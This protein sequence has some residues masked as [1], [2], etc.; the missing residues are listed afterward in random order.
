MLVA[1]TGA[2]NGLV[3]QL[4]DRLV[5]NQEATGSNP[6]ES[7]SGFVSVRNPHLHLWRI[8]RCGNAKTPWLT[9][10]DGPHHAGV[11]V[12]VIQSE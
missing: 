1:P 10:R 6:V 7:T 5:C 11:N 12:A 9:Y 4:E 8:H 2:P 3:D